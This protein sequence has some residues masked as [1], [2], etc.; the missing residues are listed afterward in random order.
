MT[1]LCTLLTVRRVVDLCRVDSAL[2]RPSA[3]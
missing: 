2:C 1:A 3:A